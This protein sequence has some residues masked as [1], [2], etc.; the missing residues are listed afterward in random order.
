M[1]LERFYLKYKIKKLGGIKALL[2]RHG[3]DAHASILI[4]IIYLLLVALKFCNISWWRDSAPNMTFTCAPIALEV[5]I[6]GVIL[7]IRRDTISTTTFNRLLEHKGFLAEIEF[8]Y[9]FP[10][11]IS[12]LSIIIWF[13]FSSIWLLVSG[14]DSI[15]K[16]PTEIILAYLFVIPLIIF[17]YGLYNFYYS[18]LATQFHDGLAMIYDKPK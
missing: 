18:I 11:A 2:G 6:I 10:I 5:A 9:D 12:I 3:T 16:I 14:I 13:L 8:Y 1:S 4:G 15:L 7:K 17:I